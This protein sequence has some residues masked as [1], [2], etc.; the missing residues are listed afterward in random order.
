MRYMFTPVFGTNKQI[1]V[2]MHQVKVM[3][4]VTAPE[5]VHMVEAAVVALELLV[6]LILVVVLVVL[7]LKFP[8]HSKIQN[9]L[10]VTFQI[11]LHSKEVV[12]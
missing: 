5:L 8:Q 1:P 4:V 7:A 10:L 12:V 3:M 9:P 2:L 11:Q 6:D